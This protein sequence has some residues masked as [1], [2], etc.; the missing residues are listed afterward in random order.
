MKSQVGKQVSR[1]AAAP[2]PPS[3]AIQASAAT[4]A[5]QPPIPRPR[6]PFWTV[7]VTGLLFVAWLG[8]L[9]YL[10]ITLPHA[11]GGGPVV[12]S[13]PQ[14]GYSQLD[15]I[16]QVESI[17]GPV[18]IKEVLYPSFLRQSPL[19]GQRIVVTNLDL[20]RDKGN[21]ASDFSG[22]G[23]YILALRP[24]DLTYAAGI[25]G[26]G[27]S[28]A[29]VSLLQA[30]SQ[31]P[32]EVGFTLSYE[33]QPTPPSPGFPDPGGRRPGPPRI[34]RDIDATRAQLKQIP[35]PE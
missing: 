30:V 31:P 14:F 3:T 4:P 12:L 28:P 9:V 2:V 24:T 13:R 18:V 25:T 34:Y 29:G 1:K 20:C 33:V 27:L 6:P 21:G 32:P 8:Y 17:A 19:V 10:V 22:P 7:P 5:P 35:K 16:A 15:V 11:P 26:L 23:P